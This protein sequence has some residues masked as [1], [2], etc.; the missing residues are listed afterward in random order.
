MWLIGRIDI[1]F[2][3]ELCYQNMEIK[4]MSYIIVKLIEFHVS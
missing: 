2:P 1:F 3:Q 4:E